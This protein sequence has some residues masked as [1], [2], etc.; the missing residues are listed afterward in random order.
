MPQTDENPYVPKQLTDVFQASK[1]NKQ[2]SLVF[3]PLDVEKVDK[4]QDEVLSLPV[5]TS[6]H[7]GSLA[8]EFEFSI[9]IAEEACNWISSGKTIKDYAT[10]KGIDVRKIYIWL[11]TYKEFDNMVK[12]AREIR[13]HTRYDMVE[14][15]VNKLETGELSNKDAK[16]MADIRRWQCEMDNFGHYGPKQKVEHTGANGDNLVIGLKAIIDDLPKVSEVKVLE[17]ES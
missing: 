8:I 15:I 5:Y 14:D 10:Y 4:L 1:V 7:L 11:R 9:E 16:V 2:S 17:H 12:E 6:K 13:G 3:I